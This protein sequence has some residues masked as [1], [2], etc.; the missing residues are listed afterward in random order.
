MLASPAWRALPGNAMKIVMRIALEHLRHGGVENGLLPVTY[1]D[2][3]KWRVRKN[4]VREAQ[5]VAI[6][7]GFIDRT[8]IGEVP[9]HGDIR[10][11]STFALTWLPRYDG[12]PPSNRWASIKTDLDAKAAVRYAKAELVR[13]RS[14]PPFFNR[15]VNQ[16]PTPK[17]A[18][19]AGN[20]SDTASGN[21]P[22]RGGRNTTAISSNDS[23]TPF[24]IPGYPATDANTATG[25][26][27]GVGKT[28]A[29]SSKKPNAG[30]SRGAAQI[31]HGVGDS[32][33]DR[34]G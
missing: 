16:N 3:A 14:L 32:S 19:W 22:V 17:D 15:Q 34:E 5:L 30:P 13:L 27:A 9:W 23:G 21:D 24:Y 18:T 20:D 8:G 33:D 26:T 10:R 6:H 31:D 12:A 29:L 25:E 4:S 11:P 7:L 28:A 1:Q 2:F